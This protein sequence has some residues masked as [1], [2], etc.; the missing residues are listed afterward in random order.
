MNTNTAE[1]VRFKSIDGDRV[2][3]DYSWI[4]SLSKGEEEVTMRKSD[5]GNQN[6]ALIRAL[7]DSKASAEWVSLPLSL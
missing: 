7:L 6:E 1:W 3:F 5:V 4:K 2:T